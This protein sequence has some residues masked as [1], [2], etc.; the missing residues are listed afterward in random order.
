MGRAMSIFRTHRAKAALPVCVVVV[1]LATLPLLAGPSWSDTMTFHNPSPVRYSGHPGLAPPWAPDLYPSS[2]SV[3]GLDGMVNDVNVVLHNVDC[4]FTPNN[5]GEEYPEDV[6]LLLA[7]PSGATAVVLSDVFGDNTVISTFANMEITLNDEAASFLPLDTN[8]YN[9][10]DGVSVTAK[11]TDDDDDPDE[12][13]VSSPIDPNNPARR[14]DTFPAPGWPGSATGP[15]PSPPSVNPAGLSIFD[16]TS[17]NGTWSLYLADD[18]AGPEWCDIK[19]GWTLQVTTGTTPEPSTIPSTSSTSSTS[20]TA[21][22]TTTTTPPA[23][24]AMA[25][26]GPTTTR[27]GRKVTFTASATNRGPAV[28]RNVV[29]TDNLPSG[30]TFA[31]VNRVKGMT[32]TRTGSL[33][34]CTVA[35]LAS[36]RSVS[37]SISGSYSPAGTYTHSVGVGT[38]SHDPTPSNNRAQVVTVV[39]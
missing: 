34:Q 26:T 29:I 18:Y 9:G 7:S 27:A 1:V 37:V 11:P 36:G 12:S 21:P 2:I 35:S 23:D 17:P 32:C 33:V 30:F 25:L 22:T 6:D 3:A 8:P 16:G 20:T 38:T 10:T 39:S 13:D 4:V 28:A 15:A 14:L 19:G 5:V 31:S 24:M